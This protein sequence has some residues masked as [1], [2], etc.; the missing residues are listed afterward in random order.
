MIKIF[1]LFQILSRI[2]Q[3]ESGTL[4]LLSMSQNLKKE[5]NT[6]EILSRRDKDNVV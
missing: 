1:F 4:K 5:G 6:V 3:K 2:K